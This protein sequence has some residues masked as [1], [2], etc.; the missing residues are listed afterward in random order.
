MPGLRE[1]FLNYSP[2]G[3]RFQRRTIIREPLEAKCSAIVRAA[4]R[5]CRSALSL[6][7]IR[8]NPPDAP[9]RSIIV[10]L[11]KPRKAKG[12]DD[13]KCPFRIDGT[14][15]RKVEYGYGVDAFQALTMALEGIR[16]FLDRLDTPLVW[17]GIF[18]DHSGFQRVI[19]S[20]PE[21]QSVRE[22]DGTCRETA[23]CSSIYQAHRASG[24]P[25]GRS[26]GAGNEA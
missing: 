18:K 23:R 7:N 4:L 15:I 13:W 3:D 14:G 11:G 24:R 8:L 20:L 26:V 5:S 1:A 22:A 6:P 17:G 10:S 25:R 9:G 12:A 21:F 16:Y 19:P 2:S